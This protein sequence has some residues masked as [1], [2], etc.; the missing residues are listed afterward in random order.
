[1]YIYLI[2][3]HFQLGIV[4]NDL[5]LRESRK[6]KTFAE[7]LAIFSAAVNV[8][9][10]TTEES[11]SNV[12]VETKRESLV[13]RRRSAFENG[14]ADN[15]NAVNRRS[16][17][18]SHTMNASS[19]K[20]LEKRH[21]IDLTLPQNVS[22]ENNQSKKGPPPPVPVKPKIK[23]KPMF[24]DANK[25]ISNKLNGNHENT[26]SLTQS[27]LKARVNES[28]KSNNVLPN[29]SLDSNT[30]NNKQNLS[31]LEG[32]LTDEGQHSDELGKQSLFN[33]SITE[34][35]NF[36][37]QASDSISLEDQISVNNQS[38]IIDNG[39]N[40]DAVENEFSEICLINLE[41]NKKQDI[42]HIENPLNEK[43]FKRLNETGDLSPVENEIGETKIADILIENS[44]DFESEIQACTNEVFINDT[45][46]ANK[47]NPLESIASEC[48]IDTTNETVTDNYLRDEI[49]K[50]TD[51]DT[52]SSDVT[53]AC[54]SKCDKE[55]NRSHT[56]ECKDLEIEDESEITESKNSNPTNP[57]PL[58]LS[59]EKIDEDDVVRKVLYLLYIMIK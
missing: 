45:I 21:S 5:K 14:K 48:A 30:V 31:D 28:T 54:Y 29:S 3:F 55:K 12:K 2:P 4:N 23:S 15:L 7:K 35:T 58:C 13:L 25:P 49:L 38:Q 40:F 24:L 19:E 43:G 34:E 22:H 1:M 32:K 57:S 18:A 41:P 52:N 6:R 16:S 33:K 17:C 8:M 59:L 47:T 10:T 37:L 36:L 44:D 53:S 11:K 39:V 27:T 9:S 20:S 51:E 50:D 56:L 46:S 26:S 42:S